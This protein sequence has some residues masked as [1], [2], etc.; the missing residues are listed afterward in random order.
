M[1][2]YNDFVHACFCALQPGIDQYY[3]LNLT[4]TIGF[5]FAAA[6][7]IS[8]LIS[9]D[10]ALVVNCLKELTKHTIECFSVEFFTFFTLWGCE[11]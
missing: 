9:L 6:V 4:L 10:C 1:H 2:M 11:E 8:P 3:Y 5:V 7:W